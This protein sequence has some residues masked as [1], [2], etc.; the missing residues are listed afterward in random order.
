MTTVF[1]PLS[2]RL[3]KESGPI[4]SIIKN[5]RDW[6]SDEVIKTCAKRM[7][8]QYRGKSN[9]NWKNDFLKIVSYYSGDRIGQAVTIAQSIVEQERERIA[10]LSSREF[11]L[12]FLFFSNAP[13]E[14]VIKP[15][16]QNIEKFLDKA[17]VQDT[18][19]ECA[20]CLN[21]EESQDKVVELS[22]KHKYHYNCI[23]QWVQKVNNCPLCKS[24]CLN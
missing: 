6:S 7:L 8:C 9:K 1:N 13:I 10:N 16:K 11:D 18:Q 20:I 19:C 23:S 3:I 12:G 15:K 21:F 22:C 17:T 14:K 4:G 2:N 24:K 5:I